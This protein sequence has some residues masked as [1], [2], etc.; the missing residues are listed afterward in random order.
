M[1]QMLMPKPFKFRDSYPHQKQALAW[2][3]PLNRIPLFLQMRLGKS[4]V[5]I[6]RFKNEWPIL[7]VAPLTTLPVWDFELRAEGIPSPRILRGSKKTKLGQLN[8]GTMWYLINYEGIRSCPEILEFNWKAIIL[9]ESTRIKNPKA[10]VTKILTEGV[11]HIENRAILSGNPKPESL[12]NLFSQFKFLYGKFM[13]FKNYWGFRLAL[14]CPDM[15]GHSWTPKPGKAAEIKRAVHRLAFIM[16]RKDAGLGNK[17]IYESRHVKM[18]SKLRKAYKGMEKLFMAELDG[19]EV[20][21]KWAM[22]NSLNMARLCGGFFDGKQVSTHKQDELISLLEGELKKEQVVVWFRFNQELKAVRKALRERGITCKGIT[23]ATSLDNRA[24]RINGFRKGKFR[25]FLCQV[26]LGKYGLNLS[27]AS[28]A[29][30][31]SNSYSWEERMQSEDRIEHPEKKEALLYID[32]VVRNTVDEDTIGALRCKNSDS[33][34]F[35][36]RLVE[37]FHKRIKKPLGGLSWQ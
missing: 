11:S 10:R 7:V 3:K 23:G 5:I 18:P 1:N 29:I 31:Y 32:L 36:S 4:K 8:G 30:Y 17:R 22:V 13:G 28:T 26:K 35:L 27:A 25:V 33:K 6:E 12:L 2:A 19:A 9:D 21:T 20:T 16:S 37:A 34:M 15:F 14:F 24:R